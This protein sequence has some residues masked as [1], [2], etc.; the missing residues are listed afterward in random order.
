MSSEEVWVWLLAYIIGYQEKGSYIAKETICLNFKNFGLFK[1]QI[2]QIKGHFY[3]IMLH[4]LS[5]LCLSSFP[6]LV[7]N[8]QRTRNAS[9]IWLD[10]QEVLN[11]YL[12]NRRV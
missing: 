7:V 4:P 10:A 6:N 9:N 1:M 12:I 8:T 5:D 3:F 11:E 2:F